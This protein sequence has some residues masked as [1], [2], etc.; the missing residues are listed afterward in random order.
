M[1]QS[2]GTVHN[3]L[4]Y[5]TVANSRSLFSNQDTSSQIAHGGLYEL[6][7]RR[8][9]QSLQAIYV[10]SPLCLVHNV[11]VL[12]AESAEAGGVW[13]DRCLRGHCE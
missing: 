1:V 4:S 10:V 7:N 5:E 3:L 13:L 6:S 11:C 12:G 9:P 2:Y 8:M